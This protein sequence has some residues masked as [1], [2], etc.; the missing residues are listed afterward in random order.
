MFA[1][2]ID[3]LEMYILYQLDGAVDVFYVNKLLIVVSLFPGKLV[4]SLLQEKFVPVLF[5]C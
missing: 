4:I 2:M 3:K 5:L 1:K